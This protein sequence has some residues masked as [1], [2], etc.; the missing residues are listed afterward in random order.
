MKSSIAIMV[1]VC[2]V[3]FS[4]ASVKGQDTT[5]GR[6]AILPFESVGIDPLYVQSAESIL[7]LELG[8]ET[9]MDIISEKRTQSALPDS[10]CVDIQCAIKVG[11]SLNGY[12]DNAR[13]IANGAGYD[14]IEPTW[15][16]AAF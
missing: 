11:Q 12:D 9:T 8:R 13:E 5:M 4:Y 14:I 10:P 3:L 6:I 1:F 2:L 7:R 16:R 15:S